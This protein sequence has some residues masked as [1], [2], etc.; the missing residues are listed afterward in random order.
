[1]T[2][3]PNPPIS[4]EIAAFAMA[5]PMATFG[6]IVGVPDGRDLDTGNLFDVAVNRCLGDAIRAD[7]AVAREMWFALAN[8]GWQHTN[9]DTASHSLRTAGDLVAAIRGKGN[10]MDLYCCGQDGVVSVRIADAMA[11]EGWTRMAAGIND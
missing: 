10:Y 8:V 3:Q 6:G 2:E 9:G 7:D 1:M 11:K 4:E 5:N